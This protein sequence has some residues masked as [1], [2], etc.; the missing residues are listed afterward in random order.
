MLHFSVTI[1]SRWKI[2]LHHSLPELRA[3]LEHGR[4]VPR[5]RSTQLYVVADEIMHWPNKSP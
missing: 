3:L 5:V 4:A 1:D 2:T